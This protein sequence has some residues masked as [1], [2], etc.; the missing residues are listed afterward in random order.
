MVALQYSSTQ[1]SPLVGEG[2]TKSG[3]RGLPPMRPLARFAFVQ[4]P[5]PQEERVETQ[6]TYP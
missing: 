6:G 3:E 2:P 4:H 5:L 1:P